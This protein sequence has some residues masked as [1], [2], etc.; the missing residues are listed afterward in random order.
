[1]TYT[2][3]KSATTTTTVPTSLTRRIVVSTAVAVLFLTGMASIA[4]A[5]CSD[6]MRSKFRGGPGYSAFGA[7][8]PQG[9]FK[10]GVITPP[11]SSF[12]QGGKDDPSKDPSIV[13]L[14]RVAFTVGGQIVDEGFD[15]WHNDGTE[16]LNDTVAPSTGNVCLGVWEQT[17]RRTYKLKHPSWTFDALGLLNGTA[18]IGEVIKLDRDG[19]TFS[20]TTTLDVYDLDENLLVHFEGEITGKRIT[21]N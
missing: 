16:I 18:I 10:P 1:M 6:D 15:V 12:G 5:S 21:V 7:G 4:R 19:K 14:W 3:R 13:G 2:T 9:S 17:A 20:G 8:Q 11:Q